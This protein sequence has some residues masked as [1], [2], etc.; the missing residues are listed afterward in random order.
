MGY[1]VLGLG[2]EGPHNNG[3][4]CANCNAVA[5]KY[6]HDCGKLYLC[7]RCAEQVHRMAAFKDHRVQPVAL[8]TQ[9]ELEMTQ[10]EMEPLPVPHPSY[11]P[12]EKPHLEAALAGSQKPPTD[13]HLLALEYGID[14]LKAELDAAHLKH[15]RAVETR[16]NVAAA[17]EAHQTLQLQLQKAESNLLKKRHAAASGPR[18]C[19]TCFRL[20][21]VC[22][23]KQPL[24]PVHDNFRANLAYLSSRQN[25]TQ[26][27]PSEPQSSVNPLLAPELVQGGAPCFASDLFSIGSLGWLMLAGQTTVPSERERAQ[28]RDNRLVAV[29]TRLVEPDLQERYVCCGDVLRDLGCTEASV[30]VSTTVTP[31]MDDL[32]ALLH[33]R[34]TERFVS[35]SDQQLEETKAAKRK[36]AEQT[37]RSHGIASSSGVKGT[38]QSKAAQRTVVDRETAARWVYKFA[39]TNELRKAAAEAGLISILC[40][41]CNSC[42]C[43]KCED[44]MT[45][46]IVWPRAPHLVA[47]LHE[48]EAAA[49]ALHQVGVIRANVPEM[50]RQGAIKA[51]MSLLAMTDRPTA[52]QAAAAMLSTLAACSPR[53]LPEGFGWQWRADSVAPLV[54]LLKFDKKRS[55]REWAARTLELQAMNGRDR[56]EAER[57]GVKFHDI[58]ALVASALGVE[59]DRVRMRSVYAKYVKGSTVYV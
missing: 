5:V 28:I 52:Q 36:Q 37:K 23:H 8:A 19:P 22:L 42:D 40:A 2:C 16:T 24:P 9:L 53:E 41:L 31:T 57:R 54:E 27:E 45:Q 58:E 35:K 29:L 4:A 34:S 46:H 11:D 32:L 55:T 48:R 51:A 6:C 14:R 43:G 25:S 7:A 59:Q 18:I 10:Q 39:A 1:W 20:K 50:I 30:G 44:L 47:G 17:A 26:P 3:K 33:Q 38:P 15:V 13:D 12:P 21:C 49:W 56:E